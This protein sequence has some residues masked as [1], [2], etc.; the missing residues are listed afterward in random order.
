[1]IEKDTQC[2]PLTSTYMC[3][4]TQNMFTPRHMY[5]SLI[6]HTHTHTHTHT[7]KQETTPSF[8]EFLTCLINKRKKESKGLQEGILPC[9]KYLTL[10]LLHSHSPQGLEGTVASWTLVACALLIQRQTYFPT[11]PRLWQGRLG[12]PNTGHPS[13]ARTSWVFSYV[14]G[15][16]CFACPHKNMHK[17]CA[18][19]QI[20]S[21][22]RTQLGCALP[23]GTHER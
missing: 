10:P 1:M 11:C 20:H 21:F 3:A 13:A 8:S 23:L 4:H 2:Q 5:P 14:D 9:V 6:T 17:D 7:N 18:N 16:I 22:P 15:A 12:S 19:Q